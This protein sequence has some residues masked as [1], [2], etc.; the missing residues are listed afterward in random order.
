[1]RNCIFFDGFLRNIKL[2][3][4]IMKDSKTKKEE[5]PIKSAIFIYKLDISNSPEQCLAFKI[6]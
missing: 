1:M 3:K 5:T 4:K 6:M 2:L